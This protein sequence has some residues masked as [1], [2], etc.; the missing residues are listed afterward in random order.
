VLY[1]DD[2]DT[3][4]SRSLHEAADVRHDGVASMGTLDDAGLHIDDQ[5]CGVRS[6]LERRHSLSCSF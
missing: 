1:P 5:E 3:F 6:V 4:L 2:G